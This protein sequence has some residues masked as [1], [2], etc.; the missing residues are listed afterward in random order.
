MTNW[1]WSP[2]GSALGSAQALP[3]VASGP[4]ISSVQHSHCSVYTSQL[5]T[6][7]WQVPPDFA[8][9]LGDRPAYK[10]V[11]EVTWNKHTLRISQQMCFIKPARGGSLSSLPPSLS[12]VLHHSLLSF[13]SQRAPQELSVR[14][15]G[16][17]MTLPIGRPRGASPVLLQAEAF[18]GSRPQ[19]DWK[20]TASPKFSPVPGGCLPAVMSEVQE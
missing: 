14:W 1:S 10:V 12:S 16:Q 11:I 6:G 2:R 20:G 8:G 19:Q 13:S 3:W 9:I 18:L 15:G 7:M 5:G 17:T 4:S